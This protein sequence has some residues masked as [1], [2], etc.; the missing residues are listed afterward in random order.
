MIRRAAL[1]M[2]VFAAATL[3]G[4]VPRAHA[5]TPE[6]T[7]DAACH[8]YDQGRWDAAA[9]GFGSLLRFGLA[10]WRLEYNLAN[11]EYKRGRLGEAILHYERARRLNPADRDVIGNLAI[12]RAKIRDVVEDEDAAGV[13]HVLRAAQDR[14]GVSLQ[15]AM[16]LAGVWLV[17]GVVT[18]CAS[19]SR[20]WTPAWGWTLAVAVFATGVVFLS[21]RASWSRLEGTP[22]AVILK[23]SVEALAGPGLNNASL[24]TLH[25]GTTATIQSEREGWFQVTLPNGLTGWVVRDAAERI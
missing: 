12:A 5:E 16:L 4:T 17:A 23:P 10:D 22:R 11:T 24:F 15:A 9:D 2:F 25:E 1:S 8:A 3:I 20:G 14:L 13:L 7:F 21:W 6:E 19:R 18:Y